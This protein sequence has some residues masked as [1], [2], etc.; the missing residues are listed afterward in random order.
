MSCELRAA[1]ER[2]AETASRIDA[3]AV[4]PKIVDLAATGLAEEFQKDNRDVVAMNLIAHLF[5][6]YP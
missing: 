6:L 5:P 2:A 1:P 3:R 4:P